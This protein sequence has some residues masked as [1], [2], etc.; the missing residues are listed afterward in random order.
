[1]ALIDA[2]VLID[3]FS[4]NEQ[5]ADWS[6]KVLMEVAEHHQLCINA[7]IYSEI[8][9]AFREPEILEENLSALGCQKLDIPYPAAFR[10]GKAFV[11]YRKKGGL[12]RSPLPDFFIGAHAATAQLTLVTRDPRRYRTYFPEVALVC[13]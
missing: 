6:G 5:W 13:P 10:A 9:I 4:D 8:S 7:V 12:K 11:Q 3:L 2:N 1:M